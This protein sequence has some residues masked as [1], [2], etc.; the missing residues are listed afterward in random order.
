MD[1]VDLCFHHFMCTLHWALITV[2]K[3]TGRV[4]NFKSQLW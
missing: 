3:G 2:V 4:G 1:N